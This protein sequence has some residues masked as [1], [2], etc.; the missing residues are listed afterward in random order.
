MIKVFIEAEAGSCNKNRYNEKTL[1]YKGVSRISWPYPYPYGF[2]VGTSAEDG[3]NLDCYLITKD[4]LKAGTIVE[5]EPIGLLEQE[6]D[7][8]VDHKVLATLP[9][10]D[11]TLSQELL[12]ELR[13]FIYAVFT[14]FPEVSVSIGRILQRKRALHH[15]QKF[16]DG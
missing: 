7:E 16:Q 9:G 14:Q 4:T 12:E 2:I 5:C 15:I 8:E 3:D 10:Q 11:V 6:E 1:E 13:D